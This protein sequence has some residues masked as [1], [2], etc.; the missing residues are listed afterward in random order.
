[1]DEIIEL[2]KRYQEATSHPSIVNARL[3]SN[4]DSCEVTWSK[5]DLY[6]GKKLVSSTTHNLTDNSSNPIS[7]FAPT[8]TVLQK[9]LNAPHVAQIVS[10][11]NDI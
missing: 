4:E 6:Q 3:S 11:L 7:N 1:M 10:K 9:A 8:E 2:E 5:V